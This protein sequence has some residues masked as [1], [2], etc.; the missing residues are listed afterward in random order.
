[1][2][3]SPVAR[4]RVIA[5]NLHVGGGVQVAASLLNEWAREGVRSSLPENL[6]C[7][8]SPSVHEN[9]LPGTRRDLPIVVKRR[10]PLS[11]RHWCADLLHRDEATLVVFG[12]TYFPLRSKRRI[13][14]YA[15]VTSLYDPATYSPSARATAVQRARRWWSRRWVARADVVIVETT[16]LRDRLSSV[17]RQRMPKNILVVPNAV[18][19]DVLTSTGQW[20]F[21]RQEGELLLAYPARPYPHKNFEFLPK[22]AAAVFGLSARRLR[23]VVTLTEEEWRQQSQSVRD[24]SLNVGPV[25][26]REIG[27]LLRGVDGVCFPSLLEA[28]SATPIEAMALGVPVFASDRDFVRSVCGRGAT[29]FDPMDARAAAASFLEAL[30]S[31]TTQMRADVGREIVACLPVA[32]VRAAQYMSLLQQGECLD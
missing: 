6:V 3:G 15:D 26:V 29:Y 4:V 17:L 12:P 19:E 5:S 7:E 21:E 8:V 30:E 14:G 13:Y 27:P 24:V 16:A 23:Y 32:G 10:R 11:I 18:N 28:F 22:L 31:G 2:N 20:Q 25:K 9:L 1:M